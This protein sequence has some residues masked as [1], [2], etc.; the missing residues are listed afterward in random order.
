MSYVKK[1]KKRGGRDQDQEE[2]NSEEVLVEWFAM[3]SLSAGRLKDDKGSLQ[4][5]G[6]RVIEA[7]SV[8]GDTWRPAVPGGWGGEAAAADCQMNKESVPVVGATRLTSSPGLVSVLSLSVRLRS[9]A[10]ARA[11]IFIYLDSMPKK[12]Y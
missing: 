3:K 10:C 5:A 2:N 11:C 8:T 1:K 9:C 6:C 4:L 7:P 12:A